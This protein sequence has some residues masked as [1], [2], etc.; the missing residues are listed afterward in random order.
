MYNKAIGTAVLA[1]GAVF[2]VSG[3]ALMAILGPDGRFTSGPHAVDAKGVAV[4]TAPTVLSWKSRRRSVRRPSRGATYGV[5]ASTS[6][7][8]RS[9]LSRRI[10]DIFEDT[11]AAPRSGQ[12][13]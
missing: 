7:L 10:A 3:L 4:V 6:G 5:S 1:L 12:P 2:A 13:L 8:A 11:P 9:I